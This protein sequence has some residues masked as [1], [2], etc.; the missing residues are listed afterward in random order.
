[1][2]ALVKYRRFL[3][4]LV[5][6]FLMG[7]GLAYADL[8]V[9]FTQQATSVNIGEIGTWKVTVTNTDS[10]AVIIPTTLVVDLPTDFRVTDPGGGI[11]TSGTSPAFHKLTWTIPSIGANSSVTET[12]TVLPGC[13]DAIPAA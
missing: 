11:E 1:M 7:T 10:T 3:G 8:T 12:F 5:V 13:A 2:S 9:A 6:V 4:V